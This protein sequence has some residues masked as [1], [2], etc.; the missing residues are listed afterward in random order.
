MLNKKLSI[1][2]LS[3]AGLFSLNAQAATSDTFQVRIAI[4]AQCDVTAGS[5]ADVD[6]GTVSST[7]TN[8]Q[9]DGSFSVLCTPG[10]NYTL[11]LNSGLNSSGPMARR[12]L[13]T[14]LPATYVDYGLFLDTARTNAW[15][16]TAPNLYSGTG[17]GS[18]QTVPVYGLVSSA[19]SAA[20][21]YSDTVT[22]TVSF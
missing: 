6:F 1:L 16:A 9:A 2:A 13:H 11:A 18:A 12:M 14:T 21:N 17:T 22:V 10:T 19:N 3:L 7:A 15:G 8:V 20:G 4:T 5:A